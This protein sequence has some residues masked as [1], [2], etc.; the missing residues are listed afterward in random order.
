MMVDILTL[1]CVNIHSL[2]KVVWI[3]L[4][5]L[6]L[7]VWGGGAVADD[8]LFWRVDAG[9]GAQSFNYAATAPLAYGQVV[10]HRPKQF[11]LLGRF[12]YIHKFGDSAFSTGLGGGYFVHPRILLSDTVTFAPPNH[13]AP[14][15][16]NAFEI[17]GLLPHGLTPY[18]RY[19][20]R[21]YDVADV[22][23]IVPGVTWYPVSWATLDANYTLALTGID[24]IS[25]ESADH[26][27]S[28]RATFIPI[29]D[30]LK[31]FAGYARTSESFDAG[32]V[33]NPFGHFH[34]NLLSL[35]AEWAFVRNM[36]IRF[37][38]AYENRDNGQTSHTYQGGVFFRF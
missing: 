18:L 10:Y 37:D 15:I 21:H 9:A 5:S 8:Q 38:S 3:S 30:R 33:V 4:F 12:D 17:L 25:S 31:F 28:V 26:S 22:H 16:Q 27:V 32:N 29:E 1:R 13:I 7:G 19:G 20:F 23:L 36:G 14:E 24:G 6:F 34:A 11:F 35:G 2:W